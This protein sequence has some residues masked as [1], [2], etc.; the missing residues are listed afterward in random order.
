ME[1]LAVIQL[2][3]AR[4]FGAMVEVV[5]AFIILVVFWGDFGYH[6]DGFLGV[7]L[8][9]G[10]PTEVETRSA[11]RAHFIFDTNNFLS[12]R[13]SGPAGERKWSNYG[14]GTFDGFLSSVLDF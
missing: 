2:D 3:I 5:V 1:F 12:A 8:Q 14:L 10:T 4:P 13:A 7:F 9:A 11:Y 6:A